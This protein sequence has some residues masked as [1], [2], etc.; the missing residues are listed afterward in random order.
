MIKTK[1]F[2]KLEEGYCTTETMI[3]LA[4][5]SLSLPQ[6]TN[7][8]LKKAFQEDHLIKHVFNGTIFG[9]TAH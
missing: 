9:V 4:Y 6:T 8:L 1:T 3:G 7:D 2:K 5:V